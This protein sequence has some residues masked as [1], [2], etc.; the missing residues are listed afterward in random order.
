MTGL[1]L[2]RTPTTLKYQWPARALLCI[3]VALAV[4][5]PALRSYYIW[6]DDVWV[7]G[8]ENLRSLDGLKQIW[9]S[10][11][12]NQE[13]Y[14]L[15]NTV[16]WIEYHL[17]GL[18]PVGY[19]TTQVLLHG[20][21]AWLAWLLLTRL[22]VPGAGLAAAIFLVHPVNVETVAWVTE[23]KNTLSG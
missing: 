16:F 9:L 13:Y 4:Y 8:N 12:S 5:A 20:V 23:H 21:T 6:D 3:V 10:P 1:R 2:A 22:R 11:T 18:N 19:H 17:W 7:V 15:T 14:P